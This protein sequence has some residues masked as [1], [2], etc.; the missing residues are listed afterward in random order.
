MY[1]SEETLQIENS[2]VQ[3]V[4]AKQAVV[5]WQIFAEEGVTRNDRQEKLPPVE[6]AWKRYLVEEQIEAAGI[7]MELKYGHFWSNYVSPGSEF[8]C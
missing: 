6:E 8:S 5:E 2:I 3:A 1:G 7:L 4:K